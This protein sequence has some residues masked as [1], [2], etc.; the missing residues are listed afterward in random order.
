MAATQREVLSAPWSC[1]LSSSASTTPYPNSAD[2]RRLVTS[3]GWSPDAFGTSSGAVFRGT[4]GASCATLDG[5]PLG[6][7]LQDFEADRLG[8]RLERAPCDVVAHRA[9]HAEAQVLTVSHDG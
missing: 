1:C 6:F 8:P 7:V 5:D 3:C 9:R 2:G 4:D